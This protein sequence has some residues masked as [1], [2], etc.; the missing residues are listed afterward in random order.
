MSLY[1]INNPYEELNNTAS[2]LREEI[3][4]L[5]ISNYVLEKRYSEKEFS[6][7]EPLAH[8]ISDDFWY[9]NKAR[10]HYGNYR[11]LVDEF[12]KSYLKTNL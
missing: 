4:R 5:M 2:A 7:I 1:N 9:K 3:M 12:M 10:V 11:E 6:K 8:Q